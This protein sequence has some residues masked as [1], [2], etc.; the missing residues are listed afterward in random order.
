MQVR[1]F[2]E[3]QEA[4]EETA[5]LPHQDSCNRGTFSVTLAS[6]REVDLIAVPGIQPFRLQ[7]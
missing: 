5:E 2:E 6:L 3:V 7:H 4:E 1:V